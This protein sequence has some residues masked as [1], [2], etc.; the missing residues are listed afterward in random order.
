MD[1]ISRSEEITARA[2]EQV[3]NDRYKLANLIFARVK[4]IKKGALPLIPADLS[5]DKLPD[6]ALQ[7]IA[8]GLIGIERIDSI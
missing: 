2:L 4:E 7:E 5:I 8:D 6:I 3:D 1:H